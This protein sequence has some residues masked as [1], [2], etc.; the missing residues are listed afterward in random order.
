[1]NY[2]YDVRLNEIEMLSQWAKANIKIV[3]EVSETNKFE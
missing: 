3:S 2:E 1:M